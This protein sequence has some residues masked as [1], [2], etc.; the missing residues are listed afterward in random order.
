M[1]RKLI[2]SLITES[3]PILQEGPGTF[4]LSLLVS[5]C[6]PVYLSVSLCMRDK[7]GG[8][9]R[10]NFSEKNRWMVQEMAF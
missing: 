7:N 2:N 5:V 9:G 6:G 1:R 8:K 10:L 4:I 3:E